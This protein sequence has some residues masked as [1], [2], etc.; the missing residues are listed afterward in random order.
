LKLQTEAVNI[1]GC[2]FIS[3]KANPTIKLAFKIFSS[4]NC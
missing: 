1:L 2:Y 4:K 3:K